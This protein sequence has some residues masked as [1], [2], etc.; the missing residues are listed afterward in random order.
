MQA[1]SSP[2]THT[3]KNRARDGETER[4]NLLSDVVET[5]LLTNHSELGL[6]KEV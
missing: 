2:H 4:D 3:Q 1:E 5:E 6:R